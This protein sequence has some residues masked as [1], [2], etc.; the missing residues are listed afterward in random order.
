MPTLIRVTK[1]LDIEIDC[2]DIIAFF[3]IKIFHSEFKTFFFVTIPT[4]CPT[5]KRHFHLNQVCLP[6]V[7]RT[8]VQSLMSKFSTFVPTIY[9]PTIPNIPTIIISC[10]RQ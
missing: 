10:P 2:D 7:K 5:F 8:A 4:C 6:A 9:I 3:V 1:M